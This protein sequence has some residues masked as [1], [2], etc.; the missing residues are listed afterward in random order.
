MTGKLTPKQA[1]FI[2][3]Y[4]VDGNG[5]R[6]AVAA[7]V[8][9]TSASVTASRWLKMRSISAVIAERRARRVH[10]LGEEAE[11][12]DR[13]LAN[14]VF[15]DIGRFYD[16]EGKRIPVHLLDED[17]RRAINSV[18]DEKRDGKYVQHVKLADK[19]RAIELLYKRKGLMAAEK[20]NHRFS[21][22]DLVTGDDGQGEGSGGEQAA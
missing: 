9:E 12:L 17:L 19:I 10:L 8:P 11:R 6:A 21:L 15:A 1:I 4:L 2:A 16:A 13:E 14:V 22:E 3:E 7:G 5:T 20:V 18:T